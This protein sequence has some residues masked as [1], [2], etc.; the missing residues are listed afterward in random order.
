MR[1]VTLVSSLVAIAICTTALARAGPPASLTAAAA[2]S[3]PSSLTRSGRFLWQFEALL[4]D[5][6]GS[7]TPH[8]SSAS[9]DTNF[10]CAGNSCY[11]HA[12]W[13]PYVF[14]FATARGSTFQLKSRS[15]RQGAFGNYPMPLRINGLYIACNRKATTYLV[16]IKGA[17]GF[18]LNCVTRG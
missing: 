8:A 10:A 3:P 13:N 1:R 17:A 6:F 2:A 7:R 11:P 9:F 12:K 14:T 5:V 15:F 4:R 16:V 18:P